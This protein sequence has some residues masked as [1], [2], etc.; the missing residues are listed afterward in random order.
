M[1][2]IT[3]SPETKRPKRGYYAPWDYNAL[4]DLLHELAPNGLTDDCPARKEPKS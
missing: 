3:A 1:V 2:A 4:A